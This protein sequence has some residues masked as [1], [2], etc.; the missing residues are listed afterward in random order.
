MAWTY[1]SKNIRLR[2]DL[3]NPRAYICPMHSTT[4]LKSA[5]KRTNLWRMGWSFR[6]AVECPAT[7]IGLK[8]I[9]AA[10]A[11]KHQGTPAPIQ[12][13]LIYGAQNEPAR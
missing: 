11:K 8:A 13:E 10:E 6:Q 3:I 5:F 9:C 4:D 1:H 12:P 7:L 2:I